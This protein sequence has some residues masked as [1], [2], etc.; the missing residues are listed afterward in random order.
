MKKKNITIDDLAIMV[1]GGFEGT[2]EQVNSLEKWTKNRF[3]N[4]DKDLQAIK[5]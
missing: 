3:D 2:K 5:K 1:Q 4:I